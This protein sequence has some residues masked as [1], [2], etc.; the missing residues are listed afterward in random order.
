M[1][2]A[3]KFTGKERDS[4]F[5][6]RYY[7]SNTGRLM[8]PD[9]VFISAQRLMDS[10]S[11]NLYSYLRN[12]PL[13]LIDDTGLDYYLSCQTSDHTGCGQVQNGSS[14]SWVQG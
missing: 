1:L 10:Q 5:G 8:S 12:N 13:R 4:E 14:S 11:Q 3:Y 7:G 6:E 2:F 9:P